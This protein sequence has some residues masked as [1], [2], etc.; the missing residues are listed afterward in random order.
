MVPLTMFSIGYSWSKNKLV[1]KFPRKF[2]YSFFSKFGQGKTDLTLD[3]CGLNFGVCWRVRMADAL[4]NILI[5]G[6]VTVNT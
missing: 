2:I 6:F 4:T 5:K 3:I 1:L